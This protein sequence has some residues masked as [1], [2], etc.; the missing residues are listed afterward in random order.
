[1]ESPARCPASVSCQTPPGGLNPAVYVTVAT[2]M[3][4]SKSW[5]SSDRKEEPQGDRKDQVESFY[6]SNGYWLFFFTA[7]QVTVVLINTNHL[8]LN[9]LVFIPVLYFS[10]YANVY[11]IYAGQRWKRFLI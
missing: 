4:S 11:D 7:R 5:G 9:Y 6:G 8:T 10:M 1:M 2:I 3:A